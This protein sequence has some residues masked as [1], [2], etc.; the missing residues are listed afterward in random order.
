M[1]KIWTDRQPAGMLDRYGDRGSAF[2]YDPEAEAGRA[3][4]VT[5]LV[6]L[7]SWNT[8]ALPRSP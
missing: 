7:P 3:V 5:M 2:V 6:R 1:I 8:N 4:S